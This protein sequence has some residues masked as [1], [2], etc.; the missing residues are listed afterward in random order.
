MIKTCVVC[1]KQFNANGNVITCSPE[2][3][4]IRKAKQTRQSQRR[5]AER[6]TQIESEWLTI[7]DAPKYEINT[8]LQVRNKKTGRF[9]KQSH[10]QGI[11][12]NPNTVCYRMTGKNGQ[13]IFRSA[14]VLR[15]QAIAAVTPNKFLPVPS[16]Q[17]LYEVNKQGVCRS[18]RLLKPRKYCNGKYAFV[19][20]G[21]AI[22]RSKAD[23]VFEVFGKI[24]KGARLK[25]PVILSKGN[26]RL[27][28]NN[29]KEAAEFLA[30]IIFLS[31]KTV[32][33][34]LTQYKSEIDG[35]QVTYV[36]RDYDGYKKEL[37]RNAHRDKRAFDVAKRQQQEN[38]CAQN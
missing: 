7:P 38:P 13:D 23:L 9:L 16:L 35:W 21:K 3:R 37:N 15:R 25:L 22:T 2:C 28:F 26:K 33:Y 27:H 30:P 34:H 32:H 18:V 17:N 19:I 20:N 8:R 11:R 4:A 14:E 36:N 1:G 31:V 6:Q 12:C 5:S 29:K 10:R 24:L